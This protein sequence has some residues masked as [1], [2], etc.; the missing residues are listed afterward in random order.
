M[1]VPAETPVTT[2][3]LVTVATAGLLLVQV[4]PVV[5]DKVVVDATQILEAPVMLTTGIP[6]TVTAGVDADKQPVVALVKVKTAV[7]AETPVT[8]PA[9][10]TVATAGSLL[11]HVPPDVGETPVM[12]PT[13]ISLD[14]VRLTEGGVTMVTDTVAEEVQ[15]SALLTVTV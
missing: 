5:G 2:P 7:P 4:P 1:A 14:P 8:T 3:A 15:P 10:V 11:D 6:F 13:Q 12:S 9:L